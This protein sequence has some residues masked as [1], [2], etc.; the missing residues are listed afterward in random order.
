MW[1]RTNADTWHARTWRS[2]PAPARRARWR[3]SIRRRKRRV[4]ARP[5]EAAA[6]AATDR[7]ESRLAALMHAALALPILAIAPRAG[8]A[9]VGEVGASVLGYQERGLMKATEPILFGHAVIDDTWE[10]EA[11]AVGDILTRASPQ[12]VTNL[13]GQ[14]VQV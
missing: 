8:A 13:S 1:R 10:L 12:L 11:S 9:V 6:V 7:P 4:G 2:M 14:P 5:W 3:R